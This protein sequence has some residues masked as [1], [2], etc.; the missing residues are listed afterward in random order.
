MGKEGRIQPKVKKKKKHPLFVAVWSWFHSKYL[1]GFEG[2]LR[3]KKRRE[4][5]KDLDESNKWGQN[6]LKTLLRERESPHE[7]LKLV[8][9]KT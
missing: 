8:L 4:M 9:M 3:G 7:N 1:K 2:G 6:L 5:G